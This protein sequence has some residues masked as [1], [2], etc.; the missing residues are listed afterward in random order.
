MPHPSPPSFKELIELLLSDRLSPDQGIQLAEL[1]EQP[2]YKDELELMLRESFYSSADRTAESPEAAKEF[3]ESI[4]QRMAGDGPGADQRETDDGLTPMSD[5]VTPM[6]RR[7]WRWFA[8][9]AAVLLLCVTGV[10]LLRRP[11]SPA[12]IQL[13]AAPAKDVLPGGNKAILVL[14]DQT[15]ITLDSVSSRTPDSVSSS[16]LTSQGQTYIYKTGHSLVYKPA[17]E[18]AAA[19][20]PGSTGAGG[21]TATATGTP[22]NTPD[23]GKLFNTV[24]TPAGGQYHLVLSDGTKVWLDSKSSL[25]FPPAFGN[26]NREVEM[27]GQ[28]YY[29]VADNPTHPFLVHT[30]AQTVTVL[31]THFNVNAFPEEG[32]V[33]T[34]LVEGAVKVEDAGNG[35]LLHPGQQASG[36]RQLIG[37]PDMEATLAWKDGIFLFNN[38]S[39]PAIMQQLS[40][41]YG[42]SVVY[43][44]SIH[45]SFVADIPREVP[46]SQVLKLL[47]LTKHVHF[48]I[49][50]KTVTVMK[51][52]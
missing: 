32:A 29:E 33:K 26:G 1:M 42:V 39:L 51:N 14:A 43:R 49:E 9:A 15:T 4:R 38:A 13:A 36:S 10:Y 40:R 46:L 35:L 11:K 2:Q 22:A 52:Q 17:A 34:T 27:T 28:V 44:D 37:H 19:S 5:D 12:P 8:A 7:D 48:E 20:T 3:L 30:G 25:R 18:G 45:A 24:M 41:W 31:G 50:N 21:S 6:R 47:E 23:P 16:V